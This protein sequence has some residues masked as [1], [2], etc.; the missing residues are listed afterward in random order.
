MNA[1]VGEVFITWVYESLR[2]PSLLGDAGSAARVA[3]RLLEKTSTRVDY[4]SLES[5]RNSTA[6]L[7]YDELYGLQHAA[8][9]CRADET[10]HEIAVCQ[11]NNPL[12]RVVAM[13]AG[14]L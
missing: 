14:T 6:H 13:P 10:L 11:R 3:Q 1:A 12:F 7:S 2:A 5:V 4:A 8:R 9:D